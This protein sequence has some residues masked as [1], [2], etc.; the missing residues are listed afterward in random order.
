MKFYDLLDNGD[1]E[2]LISLVEEDKVQFYNIKDIN[3]TFIPYLE[4]DLTQLRDLEEQWEEIV[5]RKS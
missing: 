3:D 5:A 4:K 1:D 2:K